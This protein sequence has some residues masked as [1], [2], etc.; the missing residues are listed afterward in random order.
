MNE[1]APS[2]DEDAVRTVLDDW[3]AAVRRKDMGALLRNHSADI[4]MFD[5]PPPFSST[6]IDAY[7]K[8]WEP[9][10]SWVRDPVAF[11]VTDINVVAG[12]EVA[13]VTATV[14]C[15]GTGTNG[16][17]EKLDVR[18]TAGL[19]KIRGRWTIVHEHHSVPASD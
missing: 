19:R 15:S 18:L 13:F 4:L 14:N 1:R 2:K 9:F 5:V 8:T 12:S 6:G 17:S 11:D 10:F 7:E 16:A 3:A